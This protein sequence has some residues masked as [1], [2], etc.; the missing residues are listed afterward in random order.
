MIPSKIKKKWKYS[1]KLTLFKFNVIFYIEYFKILNSFSTNIATTNSLRDYPIT[2]SL[3]S[4]PP[5]FNKLPIVLES[6]CHQSMKPDRI[7]LWLSKHHKNKMFGQLSIETIPK[8]ILD[9]QS[10]GIEIRFVNDLSSYRKIIPTLKLFPN[11]IIITVDDDLIFKKNMIKN[12]FEMHLAFPNHIICSRSRIIIKNDKNELTKY[13]EWPLNCPIWNN[14]LKEEIFG[15]NVFFN[16]G[17]GTLFPPC[18]LPKETIN[19][20]VFTKICPYSDDVWLNAMRIISNIAVVNIKNPQYL[21][22]YDRSP[23]S[24]YLINGLEN[25]ND[26]QLKSVFDKYNLYNL[27]D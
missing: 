27:I 13:S 15:I 7:I 22:F 24:L 11:N 3:T 10:R 26:I 4:I 14:K 23:F 17:A 12:L 19:E 5:R 2:V 6:L 20:E 8:Q 16:S 9:F 18:C 21:F 1:A 25:Q